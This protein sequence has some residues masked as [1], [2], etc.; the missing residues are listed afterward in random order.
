M[1]GRW[2]KIIE[3]DDE[4]VFVYNMEEMINPLCKLCAERIDS[5]MT[6]KKDVLC[7]YGLEPEATNDGLENTNFKCKRFN[8]IDDVNAI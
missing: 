4:P 1:K 6:T 5:S 7:M 2:N 8:P 3:E